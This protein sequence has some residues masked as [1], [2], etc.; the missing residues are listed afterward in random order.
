VETAFL[1]NAILC[2][3]A[4]IEELRRAYPAGL[5]VLWPESQHQKRKAQYHARF[6]VVIHGGC[7][8]L[9]RRGHSGWRITEAR[10]VRRLSPCRI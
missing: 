9:Y 3:A 8:N 1:D 10:G 4:I 6:G 2:A 5:T 7:A